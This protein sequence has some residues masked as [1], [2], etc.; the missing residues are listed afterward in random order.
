MGGMGENL[1]S[2]LNFVEFLILPSVSDTQKVLL[3][4][5]KQVTP[6]QEFLKSLALSC[7]SSFMGLVFFWRGLVGF[8]PKVI[9][10]YN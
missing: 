7:G 9:S 2:Y 3:A 1:F 5:I 4:L 8:F 6:I 10:S